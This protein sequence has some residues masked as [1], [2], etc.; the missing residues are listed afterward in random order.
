M[1]LVELNL[2]VGSNGFKRVNGLQF[3]ESMSKTKRI[4][5]HQHGMDGFFIAKLKKKS[6]H[7]DQELLNTSMMHVNKI[8]DDLDE[9]NVEG[10]KMKKVK[11]VKKVKEK[12]AQAE[13]EVTKKCPP[14]YKSKL[15]KI[16]GLSKYFKML[17]E[18][19]SDVE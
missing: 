1:E 9:I 7:I 13:V 15:R 18:K 3:D 14:I 2:E 6:N 11:K 4:W 19:D 10:D 12:V 17:K 16:W 5:P 8:K